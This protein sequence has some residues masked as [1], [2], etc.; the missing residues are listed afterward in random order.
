MTGGW[1]N[2]G[3]DGD[4]GNKVKDRRRREKT[5]KGDGREEKKRWR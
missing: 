3:R 4:N 1:G 2:E 5:G